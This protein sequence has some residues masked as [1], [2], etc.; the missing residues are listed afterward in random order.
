MKTILLVE[1]DVFTGMSEAKALEGEGYN[2]IHI[3]TGE[4]AIELIASDKNKIDL[5][6]ID[7]DLGDGIDGTQT[8]QEILK[9]YDIPIVF[10]SSHTEKNIVNKT[11]KITPYGYVVK[12][13]GMPVLAASLKIA[14]KLHKVNKERAS[15]LREVHHRVKNNMQLIISLLRLQSYN[16]EN[17]GAHAA[18]VN[19]IQRIYTMAKIHENIYQS[20]NMASIEF[21]RYL[22]DI[23]EEIVISYAVN[24]EQISIALDIQD[25]RL[26]L[27]KAV[28]C[29]LLINE[30]FSNAIKH[31]CPASEK[32]NLKLS[33][34]CEKNFNILIIQDNGPGI[35]DEVLSGKANTLG[36]ELI[37]SLCQQ[38]K[39]ELSVQNKSGTC[40]RIAIPQN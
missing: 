18:L 19:C 35:P 2:V 22:E 16:L 33:F 6:L 12:K 17:T 34:V 25:C 29:G 11:E 40:Y 36:I 24:P 37:H 27:E 32:S 5:V 30:I 26:S 39:A 15:L 28:P 7:I 38:L 8:A 21:R 3:K 10:L 4:Q 1:N 13:C 31:G 14:F 20:E 23:V 9:I